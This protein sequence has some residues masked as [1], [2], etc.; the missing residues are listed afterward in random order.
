MFSFI[1]PG[2]CAPSTALRMPAK[3][4]QRRQ[5]PPANY[6][7]HG[8][9]MAEEITFVLGVIAS[10]NRFSTAAALGTGFGSVTFHYDARQR[11]GFR[12]HGCSPPSCS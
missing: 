5:F 11:A 2:T 10:L 1:I 8:G 3:P 7:G 9:D 4:R 12:F 6:S